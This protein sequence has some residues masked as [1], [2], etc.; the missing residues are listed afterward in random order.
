MNQTREICVLCS[1]G[2]FV[3]RT[4]RLAVGCLRYYPQQLATIVIA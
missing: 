2:L 4:I 1:L 3:T